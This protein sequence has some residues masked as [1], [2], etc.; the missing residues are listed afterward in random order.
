M[1]TRVLCLLLTGLLCVAMGSHAEERWVLASASNSGIGGTNWTTDAWIYSQVADAPIDV[2]V[3]FFPTVDGTESPVEV[4]VTVPPI[5]AVMVQDI[6][7]DLFGEHRPGALRFR[8]DHPFEV[9]TRTK[10]DGDGLGTF[11]Q[12]IPGVSPE[13]VIEGG[14]LLGATNRTGPDGVRTNVGVLNPGPEPCTVWVWV[15]DMD[16]Q[17][18]VGTFFRFDDLAPNGWFQ[19]NAFELVGAADE[20]VANAGVYVMSR[21]EGALSYISRVDTAS[22]DGTFILPFPATNTYIVPVDWTVQISLR[23]PPLSMTISSITYTGADGVD[24]VVENPEPDWSETVTIRSPAEFCYTVE[25]SG[26]G[27]IHV[28]VRLARGN[29]P[30]VRRGRAAGAPG[31]SDCIDLY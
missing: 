25:G 24:V 30:P 17:G 14:I 18:F 1:K 7:N 29:D 5:S 21:G 27:I 11:G 28:D 15:Y 26:D 23:Y 13:D 12:G 6:V 22:G 16:A 8:S 4:V 20:D 9:R 10:N 2:S 31:F 3:A 19:A